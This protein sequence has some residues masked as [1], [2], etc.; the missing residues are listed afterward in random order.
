MPLWCRRPIKI[1][2]RPPEEHLWQNSVEFAGKGIQCCIISHGLFIPDC[3][4]TWL[5][6]EKQ[7]R[8]RAI[9]QQRGDGK[10]ERKKTDQVEWK[11]ILL[12]RVSAWWS[13]QWILSGRVIVDNIRPVFLRCFLHVAVLI[14]ELHVKWNCHSRYDGDFFARNL[15][16]GVLDRVKHGKPPRRI[17]HLHYCTSA[18]ALMVSDISISF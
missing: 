13:T 1:N 18:H 9:R 15:E 14:L 2:V 4:L 3:R 16:T 5:I 12:K 8:A 6:N 11:R 7:S 10:K 17:E